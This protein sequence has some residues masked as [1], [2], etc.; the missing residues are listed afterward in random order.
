MILFASEKKEQ[1]CLTESTY[2]RATP[3]F[4]KKLRMTVTSKFAEVLTMK[5]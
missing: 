3:N 1:K 5:S 2:K 4:K